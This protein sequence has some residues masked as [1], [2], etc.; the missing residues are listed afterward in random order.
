MTQHAARQ[1]R[2]TTKTANVAASATTDGPVLPDRKGKMTTEKTQK[3]KLYKAQ[4]WDPECQCWEDMYHEF[5]Q[6]Y[7][8]YEVEREARYQARQCAYPVK[9]RVVE[10]R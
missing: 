1:R 7:D 9:I 6:G 5:A 3:R 4:Q 10:A 2:G 8:R